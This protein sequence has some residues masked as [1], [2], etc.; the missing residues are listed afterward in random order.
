MASAANLDHP[1]R[2]EGV[3]HHEL[4]EELSFGPDTVLRLIMRA[5]PIRNPEPIHAQNL[6]QRRSHFGHS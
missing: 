6:P 4:L 3:V 2:P 1:L 5:D